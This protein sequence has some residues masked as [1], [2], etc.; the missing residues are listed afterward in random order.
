MTGVVIV[1]GVSL[2]RSI[3]KIRDSDQLK[4]TL[5]C[6][7]ITYPTTDNCSVPAWE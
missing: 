5:K 7:E 6:I 3:S 4:S 1:L 2:K